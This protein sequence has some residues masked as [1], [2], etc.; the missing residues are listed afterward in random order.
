MSAYE[1]FQAATAGIAIGSACIGCAVTLTSALT[2]LL[3][4][5][6]KD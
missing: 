5:W 4:R 3:K 1:C 6:I 2:S